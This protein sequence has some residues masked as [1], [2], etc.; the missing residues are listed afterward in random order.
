[1]Y[2]F[3]VAIRNKMYDWRIIK[4]QSFDI[5]IVCVGNLTVGGTGK[6]PV[7]EFLIRNLGYNYRIAVL[8]RGYGRKTKGY[9]EVSARSSFLKVGDEPKQIKR[10][11]ADVVVAVCEDRCTG[12]ETIRKRH[13]D[14]DLI[15]MDDGF[16]HR[17]VKPKINILLIDDTRPAYN[18]HMLPLGNLRDS[19]RQMYRAQFVLTTKC[20]PQMTALDRRIVRKNLMLYPYQE[21]Y[22]STMSYG[23]PVAQFPD[24]V[25]VKPD[26][27]SHIIVMAGVGNPKPLVDYLQGLYTVVDSMLMPDHHVYRVS[28][29]TRLEQMLAAAPSDTLVI[30]TEKDGVKLTNTSR[31]PPLVAQRLYVLPLFLNIMDDAERAFVRNIHEE[32]QKKTNN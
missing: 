10:K 18:D 15:I 3:G 17:R 26:S 8:S 13:P 16:Q 28:D 21:L 24:V 11:F 22:F 30:T 2:A 7:V 9:L 20:N 25:T 27:C 32:I 4:E 6:T 5:P 29:M 23:R 19:L 12:I 31:V 14:V 1:M